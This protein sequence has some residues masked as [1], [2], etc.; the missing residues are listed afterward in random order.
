MRQA[1][2]ALKNARNR[3]RFVRYADRGHMAVTTDVIKDALAFI[4][5]VERR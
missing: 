5:E 1:A 2:Q 3:H 4:A